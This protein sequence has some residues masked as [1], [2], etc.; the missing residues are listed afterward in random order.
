MNISFILVGN[1]NQNT[2]ELLHTAVGHI[3]GVK[4]ITF[5]PSS[6]ITTRLSGQLL[7]C[8]SRTSLKKWYLD[9]PSFTPLSTILKTSYANADHETPVSPPI[10]LSPI[11]T[12]KTDLSCCLETEIFNPEMN[13]KQLKLRT[14][15][16]IDDMRYMSCDVCPLIDDK[17]ENVSNGSLVCACACSDG[18][19]R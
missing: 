11:T 13:P 19:V 5:L 18:A 3:V 12:N 4:D 9:C 1:E 7:S 6:Q 17:N 2:A 8:G 10:I 15:E 14:G 16:F